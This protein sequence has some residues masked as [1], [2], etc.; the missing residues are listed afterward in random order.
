[1]TPQEITHYSELMARFEGY[2]RVTVNFFGTKRGR[3]KETQWQLANKEWMDDVG[4]NDVGEYIVDVKNNRFENWDDVAYHTD[5]NWL[6]R[7][8]VKFRDLTKK[9]EDASL[10]YRLCMIRAAITD[11][12]PEEAFLELGKAIEW[13]FNLKK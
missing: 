11:G 4:L 9:L 6:H 13:Y 12:T 10:A 8:W 2:E 7:V 1:M 3:Y 5:Y